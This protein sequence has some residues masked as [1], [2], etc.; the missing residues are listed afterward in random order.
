MGRILS[1][2]VVLLAAF[3]LPQVLCADV[4]VLK[5]VDIEAG[6]PG[7]ANYELE[8]DADWTSIRELRVFITL[9]DDVPRGTA[10]VCYLKDAQWNWYQCEPS[11]SLRSGKTN[12]VRIDMTPAAQRWLPRGHNRQWDGYVAHKIRG[13]GVKLFNAG[14]WHGK[15]RIDRIYG[16]TG[17]GPQAPLGVTDLLVN[18]EKVGLFEKF[19]IS[20]DLTRTYENP[21]DPDQVDIRAVFTSP[22]GKTQEQFAFLYR[23]FVRSSSPGLGDERLTPVGKSSW[24]VRWTPTEVGKWK[25]ELRLWDQFQDKEWKAAVASRFPSGAGTIPDG[26]GTKPSRP[27]GTS[28]TPSTPVSVPKVPVA[29][30]WKENYVVRVKINFECVPLSG[31]AAHGFIRVDPKDPF[32]FSYQD[33]AFFYPIG[34]TLRSPTDLRLPYPAYK[35]D[36]HDGEGTYL[37]DRIMKKLAPSGVNFIRVWMSIWWVGLEA[38]KDYAP[39]YE[40]LGRYNMVNAWKLDHI[41]DEAHRLGIKVKLNLENH[42]QLSRHVD[43]EFFESSYN[44]MHGGM[45]SNPPEFWTNA[46]A[47]KYIKRRFRYIVARW[48]YSP[49]LLG[50]ELWSEVDLTE[51]FNAAEVADWH[52]EFGRYL[53]GID[54]WKHLVSTHFYSDDESAVVYSLPEIDFVPGDLYQPNVVSS[55]RNIWIRKKD[56]NKPTFISEYGVGQTLD[57]QE[58]NFHGGLWSSTVLPMAGTAMYWWWNLVDEKN[59]YSYYKAVAAFNEGEDRRGKAWKL[60]TA[61]VRREGKVQT[62]VEVLGRQ[63]PAEAHLWVYDAAIYEQNNGERYKHPPTLTGYTLSVPGFEPGKYRVEFWDTTAGKVTD[64]QEVDNSGGV[65]LLPLPA[66]QADVAVKIKKTGT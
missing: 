9:P 26:I 8:L 4:E 33:G 49:E 28:S 64:T 20:F 17:A 41:M 53:K 14:D 19:E 23:D 47:K 59:L 31:T 45:L 39:G 13:F 15:I 11:G 27:I 58:T 1:T 37:F 2:M 52:R 51:G 10:L 29:G 3:F 42:G 44:K 40:G 22:S 63:N 12:E 7:E 24:K 46:E 38:P 61:Q 57:Q 18:S 62:D 56:F 55:M 43:Q 32:Y 50:W 6:F 66:I 21:F 5:N 48:A 65:F 25:V 36:L 35:G 54:P 60:T 34:Q 30:P 16:R